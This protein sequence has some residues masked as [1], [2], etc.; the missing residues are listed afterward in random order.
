ME[1]IFAND[2]IIEDAPFLARTSSTGASPGSRCTWASLGEQLHHCNKPLKCEV[3]MGAKILQFNRCDHAPESGPNLKG[4]MEE[5]IHQGLTRDLYIEMSWLWKTGSKQS[6]FLRGC[7]KCEE[8][9]LSVAL[10]VDECFEELCTASFSMI[11]GSCGWERKWYG[12]V[13]K[14][15]DGVNSGG[16][17]TEPLDP[18]SIRRHN[19]RSKIVKLRPARKHIMNK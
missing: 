5:A 2:E 3:A 6:F 17:S 15:T 4:E 7:H 19:N 18:K 1:A 8:L 11:C 13:L 14:S 16:I 10:E 9:S 12:F